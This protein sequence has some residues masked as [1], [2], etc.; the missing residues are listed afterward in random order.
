MC[1]HLNRAGMQKE[2]ACRPEYRMSAPSLPLF[3]VPMP[4]PTPTTLRD[5][6]TAGRQYQ[7]QQDVSS[8][9]LTSFRS[10][11]A[12]LRRG[13]RLT[14]CSPS[15]SRV[16]SRAERGDALH[17]MLLEWRARVDVSRPP[18]EVEAVGRDVTAGVELFPPD[19]PGPSQPDPQDRSGDAPAAALDPLCQRDILPVAM[20][21]LRD[22][23][24]PGGIE[25][26]AEGGNWSPSARSSASWTTED[27]R[28]VEALMGVCRQ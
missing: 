3:S 23:G 8:E 11:A 6:S 18:G 22:L 4:S 12:R 24:T 9:Q 16:L 25:P 10:E 7:G 2:A 13:Y 20:E 17:S 1:S 27:Q 5:I 28:T 21:S 19:R 26:Q 15:P 14:T